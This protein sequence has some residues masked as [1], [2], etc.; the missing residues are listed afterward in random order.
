MLVCHDREFLNRQIRRV[1]SFEP[2][3]VRFYT[4]NYEVYRKAREEEKKTLEARARNQELKIKEAKKFIDRFKAKSTKA[5]QAQSKIKLIRKMK[6]VETHRREKTIRFTFPPAARCGRVVINI[7]GL[8]KSFGQNT[9]YED[10]GLDVLRGERVAIIGPNG[11]G[12]TTLLRM[13]TGEI[14]PDNGEIRPGHGV[15][16]SY[17]A[18]HHTE[19]LEPNRT[20][21][22]EV[23]QVV[24]HESVTFVRQVCGAFLFSGEDVDKPV[25]VLSGGEKAR[26][27][28]A[29][30]LV[31]P[32]NLLVMDEPTNHL[33]LLSSETLIDA[34]GDY[35][36]TIL[37]VSHNRSFINRL[38][39][40]ILDI[41]ADEIVVYP[42]TLKEYEDHLD[43]LES[44]SGTAG[45][46]A[47]D[48]GL[49]EGT[50]PSQR[51][52]RSQK[53]IRR[54]KAERRRLINKTLRPIQETL[55]RLES[56]IA[57]LE[58]REKEIEQILVDPDIFKQEEGQV[59][60][61]EYGRIKKR[62]EDLMEGWEDQQDRLASARAAL[63][64]DETS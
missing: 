5:R 24:P 7:Q 36:G 40:K 29:K 56:D 43:R 10:F 57:V 2:E 32:G 48:K 22:E 45:E 61:T 34:L 35:S 47:P 18:Q 30:I 54:E 11:A 25:G 37:F 38:A 31:R 28:L 27:C 13:I 41:Q 14:P 60:L 23:Y 1:I 33:D 3:G 46:S 16:M 44:V 49:G 39:T 59:L 50:A 12:K 21:V 19:M 17:Y 4:G 58:R 9:L 53:E 55:L 6:M 42:G 62:L 51:G 52:R 8:S 20:I 15:T 26:V 63:G 64:L